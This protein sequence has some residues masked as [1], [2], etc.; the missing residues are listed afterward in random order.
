MFTAI[1]AELPSQIVVEPDR[2]EAVGMECTE[3]TAEPLKPED[4]QPFASVTLTSV[5]VV[6]DAGETLIGVALI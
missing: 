4:V 2:T 1:A 3:I 5:Y 6:P